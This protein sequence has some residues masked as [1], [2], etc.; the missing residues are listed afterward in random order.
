MV[1]HVVLLGAELAVQSHCCRKERPA[2]CWR[3][4]PPLLWWCPAGVGLVVHHPLVL[5]FR[6]SSLFLS[7]VE[8]SCYSSGVDLCEAVPSRAA[9]FS[10]WFPTL[11][12]VVSSSVCF[13]K[14]F[15][16]AVGP[17]VYKAVQSND[18]SD[19][20]ENVS[21][22]KIFYGSQTGTAKVEMFTEMLTRPPRH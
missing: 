4:C 15:S 6:T 1:V 3:S 13:Q 22:V 17:W 16:K 5:L 9:S 18:R 21:G 11:R 12:S 10:S 19:S 2:I 14:T 7:A 8:M 20:V